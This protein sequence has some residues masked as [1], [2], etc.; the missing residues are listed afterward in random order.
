MAVNRRKKG[1][2]VA[3]VVTWAAPAFATV[4]VASAEVLAENKQRRGVVFVNDSANQ[5]YLGVGAAAVV[6]SGIRLNANGG[7]YEINGDNL[8]TQDIRAIATAA[9]SNLTIMEAT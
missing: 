5:I 6:G 4:G 8:T 2:E 3:K 9:S 7:A 1:G